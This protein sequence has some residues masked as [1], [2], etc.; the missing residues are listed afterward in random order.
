MQQY[1]P[2]EKKSW[3]VA[4]DLAEEYD[5]LFAMGEDELPELEPYFDPSAFVAT[6]PKPEVA[7]WKLSEDQLKQLGLN[8]TK[9]R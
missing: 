4:P 8:T 2:E 7:V 9:I 3:P 5:I 1:R 6:N